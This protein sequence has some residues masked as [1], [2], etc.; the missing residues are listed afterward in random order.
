MELKLA[1]SLQLHTDREFLTEFL[2]K[3]DNIVALKSAG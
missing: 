1:I 2:E 3:E